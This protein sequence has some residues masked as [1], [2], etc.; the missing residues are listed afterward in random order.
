M[1]GRGPG[2]DNG[3]QSLGHDSIR[4]LHLGDLCQNDAFSVRLAG[5]RFELSSALPHS[6]SFF[7]RKSGRGPLSTLRDSSF[8][9]HEA[10][11]L[12]DP[13]KVRV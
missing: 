3:M 13:L 12:R 11:N 6:G 2:F 9:R 4:R 8:L 7:F 10:A 1:I 5:E